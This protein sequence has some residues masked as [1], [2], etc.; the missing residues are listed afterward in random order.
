M[1][2]FAF[3]ALLI[4]LVLLFVS[5][6]SPDDVIMLPITLKPGYGGM[7][8]GFSFL[9]TTDRVDSTWIN[10]KKELK[11]IPKDW[12]KCGRNEIWLD[13][14][15]FTYQNY[16]SGK[17]TQNDYNEYKEAWQ[18]DL[19][20]KRYSDAEI[21]C[22]FYVL[23]GKDKKEVTK[24]K[25]DTNN[26]LN[27]LDE[28]EFSP[29]ILG[30]NDM[31]VL[32]SI[33]VR[34]AINVQYEAL[35]KGEVTKLTAPVLIAKNEVGTLINIAQHAEAILDGKIIKISSDGFTTTC[36]HNA[37]ITI[38]DTGIDLPAAITN[39]N[40]FILINGVTYQNL[41]VDTNEQTL[42]LRKLRPDEIVYSSQPG[43]FAKPFK[44]NEFTS[45]QKIALEDYSGK[46]VLI[47]FWGTWC[48]PCVAEIP[49]LKNVYN[50][51]DHSK[52]EFL[53][54]A[55]DKSETL[56]K[57]LDKNELAWKQILCESET[58]GIVADYNV[59]GFPT[60][61][62]IDPKGKIIAKNLRGE[63]LADTLNY[64]LTTYR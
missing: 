49:N 12:I 4:P 10:T 8:V 43:F 33:A 54:I 59:I 52:I 64:Y 50:Q 47:E 36:Y 28:K 53:G 60:S 23:L 16:K 44:A 61:F 58:E 48:S 41:G 62:L 5:T 1:K 51:L 26:D 34:E 11:G 57:F 19:A 2:R 63:N 25:I 7:P 15:Q 42:M 22:S 3:L 39:V 55:S 45:Q 38:N 56:R 21:K 30:K 14:R 6:K 24:C 29:V 32:D 31:N 18:I 20:K 27:F 13:A 35:R 9:R 40:E 46:F 37:A 17:L